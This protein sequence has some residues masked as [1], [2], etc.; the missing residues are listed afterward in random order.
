MAGLRVAYLVSPVQ[1][2]GSLA[3]V[4]DPWSISSLAS[5]AAMAAIQD[6]DYI[7]GTLNRNTEERA[8]LTDAL[9]AI[10]L[11]VFPSHANFL[12]F[13]VPAER[14]DGGLWERLIVDHGIVVRNCATFEGL[15]AGYLRIAVRG[16]EDNQRLVRALISVLNPT[17]RSEPTTSRTFTP[18][19]P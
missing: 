10:G 14:R 19:T 16:R 18:A 5:I 17:P 6:S 15:D 8:W 13:C 3:R 1:M 9:R 7:A 4:L 2:V 12:L 11:T